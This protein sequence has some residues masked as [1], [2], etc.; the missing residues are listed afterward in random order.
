MKSRPEFSDAYQW[1]KSID[2]SSQ[3]INIQ[4]NIVDHLQ[5]IYRFNSDSSICMIREE[6]VYYDKNQMIFYIDHEWTEQSKY[7]RDI[8]HA[9]ARIFLPYHNDELVRSLG[10]F[11]N[12]LHN[13]E[14]NNLETFAKYQNFDLEFN[15]SDD[16][17]WQIPSDSKQIK[18]IE[19]KIGK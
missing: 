7:Y 5:L 19:P 18:H 16:I 12:L 10:N 11:M 2:M 1:T 8:F 3:L 14:E 17:P 6:K 4:F 13:E 9:F 15:D